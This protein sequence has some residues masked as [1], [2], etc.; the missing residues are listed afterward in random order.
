MIGWQSDC[1]QAANVVCRSYSLTIDINFPWFN[2]EFLLTTVYGLVG[3]DEKQDFL[4]ELAQIRPTP[5]TAWIVLDDFNL[6]Y[7]ALRQEQ[8][9]LKPAAHG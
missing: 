1:V 8:F 3:N 9:K 6:I 7:E 5:P 4:T 2:S